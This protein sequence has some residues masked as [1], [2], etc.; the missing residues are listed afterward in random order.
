MSED[1]KYGYY[2]LHTNSQIIYVPFE[3]VDWIGQEA[4]FKRPFI[5]T[6]G[7]VRLKEDYDKVI[8]R[9]KERSETVLGSECV[10]SFKFNG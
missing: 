8:T 1:I 4:Y 7:M 3:E 2:Y 9:L 5:I 10:A 6:W